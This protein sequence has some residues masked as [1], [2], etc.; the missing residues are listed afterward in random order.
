MIS[1]VL[2]T[3]EH[4]AARE[5]LNID[6]LSFDFYRYSSFWRY[7]FNFCGIYYNNYSSRCRLIVVDI[8]LATSR[9]GK[10]LPLSTSTSVNNC[11]TLLVERPLC[12]VRVIA[13]LLYCLDRNCILAAALSKVLI[14]RTIYRGRLSPPFTDL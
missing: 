3:S 11:R 9:C 4:R 12:K 2:F 7:L 8:Y 1:R 13:V 6:H 14:S 5:T 10:Y